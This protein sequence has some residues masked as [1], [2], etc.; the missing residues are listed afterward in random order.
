[1]KKKQ[2]RTRG[3]PILSFMIAASQWSCSTQTA[4][5]DPLTYAPQTPYSV[6]TPLKKSTLIS[7]RYCETLLPPAFTDGMELSLAELIDISL[8][9]NPN[10]KITWAQARSAAAL[11]GQSLNAYFPALTATGTWTRIRQSYFFTQTIGNRDVTTF[12]PYYLTTVTPELTLTYTIFDF[13][14]RRTSSETARQA[15]FYAD[16]THNQE[17]QMIIQLAM[18]D[19]YDYLYQKELLCAYQADLENATASLDAAEQKLKSGVANLGDTSQAK[20]NY[21]QMKINYVTQQKNVENSFAKLATDI[22]LPANLCFKVQN[23]PQK[24]CVEPI[25]EDIQDLID[26]AQ[27]QRADLLAAQADVKSKEANLDNATL[28]PW[29]SL[30]GYV[31]LGK[32]WWSGGIVED[33]HFTLT[34]SFTFPLFKG[35]YYRNAI[36][37]AKAN[38]AQ[39]QATLLE[40]ELAIIKDVTTSY[41][42][43]KT[44]SETVRFSEEYLES[45]Q[46]EFDIALGKYR[47]GTGTILNV[48]SAQSSLADARAKLASS[49][50]DWYTS[51]AGLAY[52]TGSLCPVREIARQ[53]L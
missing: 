6:W 29:P 33:C 41:Q 15:L 50:R 51:L 31:D 17:I 3:F 39:S 8:Q 28:T 9:N 16:W 53:E 44:S 36:K 11:Y 25:L 13:G 21:L 12:T 18:D 23:L 26:K 14:Q 42:N 1:M 32:N 40:T 7:S 2:R 43:L 46:I 19:Y 52:A 4:A 34:F 37:N 48:L 20:T 49:K 24:V 38:L 47:A 22:G 45:A 30:Q 27:N 10:T 5:F 35:F